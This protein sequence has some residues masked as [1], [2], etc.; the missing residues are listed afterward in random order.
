MYWL[1]QNTGAKAWPNRIPLQRL[2]S[3]LVRIVT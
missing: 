3:P 2:A 1:N